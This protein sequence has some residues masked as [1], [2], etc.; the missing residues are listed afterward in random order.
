MDAETPG[1]PRRLDLEA[2]P[3]LVKVLPAHAR[4]PRSAAAWAAREGRAAGGISSSVSQRSENQRPLL[5]GSDP[6]QL[7]AVVNLSAAPSLCPARPPALIPSD[8]SPPPPP[9]PAR[10]PRIPPASSPSARMLDTLHSASHPLVNVNVRSYYAVPPASKM[11]LTADAIAEEDSPST[12]S[13]PASN[14]DDANQHQQ[15]LLLQDAARIKALRRRTAPSS[16]SHSAVTAQMLRGPCFIYRPSFGLKDFSLLET[17]GTG[18]FGRV[19]L[20]KFKRNGSYYAMKVLKK[21]ELVRLKQIEHINSE[22]HILSRLN[23]PFIVNLFCTFQDTQYL[24]MLLEYVPGGE[25]FS[26]LRRAGR[27]SPDTAR[28]YAAEIVLAIEHLHAQNVI[29]RDLKPENLLLDPRGHIRITDF[30]FA[31][32]VEDR[33]WTLCGTPEY[34]APEIINSSGHGKAVDWWALGILIFE[35]LAGYPPFYD[36]NPFKIYERI[37]AGR[38]HFP[39]YIDPV[40][41][42]LIKRLLTA[43]RTRRL[44]NLR[45]GA[46]DI[47]RHKW[48]RGV[49]WQGLLC[50]TVPAP[51]V[52]TV[53]HSGDTSN[54]EKY[55]EVELE[56]EMGRMDGEDPYRCYFESF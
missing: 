11:P 26:H 12:T 2:L 44:G 20:A 48:F 4:R 22:R 46:D 45:G 41:K 54:F 3:Y 53:M 24:Y 40:A 7:R 42:D 28:F 5:M 25:L 37:L 15:Q 34:L 29:Y 39:P 35:M 47:K 30:G 33:T 1:S 13:A 32:H 6:G 38:I 18:T 16:L 17:L 21:A 19:Y 49:D 55:P 10:Y 31:K 50:K 36:D 23:F 43:D 52:P 14:P 51:I 27:F 9:P 56:D 8:S